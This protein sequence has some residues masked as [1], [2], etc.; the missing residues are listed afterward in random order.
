MTITFVAIGV[1]AFLA[2]AVRFPR[3]AGHTDK[4]V[5]PR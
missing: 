4:A 5:Q 2:L 1:A 3:H